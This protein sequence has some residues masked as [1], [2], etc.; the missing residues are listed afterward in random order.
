VKK[1]LVDILVCLDLKVKEGSLECPAFLAILVMM[2][3][4]VLPANLD[5]LAFQEKMDSLGFL[6]RKV[7]RH[8]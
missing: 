7:N 3:F 8:V 4:L 1:V 5:L 6:D 2:V